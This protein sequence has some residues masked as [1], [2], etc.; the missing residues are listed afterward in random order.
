MNVWI[1]RLNRFLTQEATPRWVLSLVFFAL[2]WQAV[3]VSIFAQSRVGGVEKALSAWDAGWYLRIAGEGYSGSGWAFFPLYP[4]L[5]AGWAALAGMPV[6]IAGLTVSLACYVAAISIYLRATAG[7]TPGI[8]L[9]RG[10]NMGWILFVFS[11]AAWVFFHPH[12]ESLY[13]LLLCGTFVLWGK[14]QWVLAAAVAGL[15]ALTKNQGTFLALT[16]GLAAGFDY[17][18]RGR[19]ISRSVA[20]F[21]VCGVISGSLYALFLL[22]QYQMTGDPFLFLHSQVEWRPEMTWASYVKTFWFGNPW[23]NTNFGSLIHHA[24]FFILVW[25]AFRQAASK[26]RDP[27]WVYFALHVGIM[28]LSGELVT[29]FRYAA[30]L[31]PLW[32]TGGRWLTQSKWNLLP[33]AVL[34]LTLVLHQL[35]LRNALVGRWAY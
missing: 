14:K 26:I 12:T 5:I 33:P 3:V 19:G 7:D 35:M 1:R 18:S 9:P 27:I 10:N 25:C 17:W 30:V 23:Q 11:P 31:L 4:L 16:T 6:A 21:A 34:I 29:D 28:P 8:H 20:I 32:L 24:F 22:Y 15:S 2:L 13:L